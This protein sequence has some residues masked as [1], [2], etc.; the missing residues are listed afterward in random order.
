[1]TIAIAIVIVLF[2]HMNI[3]VLV[4]NNTNVTSGLK[5]EHGLSFW[6][7]TGGKNIL[8]DVG[9]TSAF[10]DNAIEMGVDIATTDYLVLSHAH[11]DHVGGLATFL[12]INNK[13]KIYLSSNVRERNCFSTRRGNKRDISIDHTLLQQH[14]HR[15]VFVDKDTSIT[16]NVMLLCEIPTVYPMPKANATLLA[17]DA[18]DDFS[19][20]LAVVVTDD[21]KI[22]TVISPCT[23][24]G[25]LNVLDAIREYKAVN[26]IG[27]LHL[28]DSDDKNSFESVDE[29]LYLAN[30][31]S[32]RSISLYTG[33]CTGATAKN[34]LSKELGNKYMDFYSGFTINL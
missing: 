34:I 30:E 28:L 13:A 5:A 24:R 11:A 2:L 25:I 6:L 18:I 19:H 22:A 8:V 23:H 29:V 7:Q 10:A 16:N 9:E 32:K 21:D 27:G 33:H 3:K 15:F 20:E 12:A 14:K 26:F 17:N 1:M 31:I 4:D